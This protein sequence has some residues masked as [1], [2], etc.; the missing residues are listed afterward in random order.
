MPNLFVW[1]D[2]ASGKTKVIREILEF[3]HPP[4]VYVNCVECYSARILFE[5]I[6]EKMVGHRRT[7]ANNYSGY[8]KYDESLST[9]GY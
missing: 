6:I 7:V 3:L 4:H 5:L 2:Y 8:L 9:H 1:G